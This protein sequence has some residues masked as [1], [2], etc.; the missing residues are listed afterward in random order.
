LNYLTNR[1]L[2][3]RPSEQQDFR[4]FAVVNWMTRLT[5][6]LALLLS[7]RAMAGDWPQFRGP[8]GNGVAQENKAPLHWGP[9]TNVLW[10]VTLPGPGNSSPIVSHGRVFI[11][12]AENEGRKRN[13]Y[14]FDRRTGAQLWVRTV[15]FPSVEPTHQSNP[16]CGSTPVA[17]G[18]RVVVWH[19]SAGVFCYNFKGKELW[20]TDLGE[21]R[22]EWGYGS[23]PILHRG[24]IILN[25]GPGER[26]FLAALD[27]RTG[28]LL[29]K[30]DEPGGAKTLLKGNWGSWCTPIVAKVG[31]KDQVLCSM[32]TQ[33]VACDPKTGARLWFCEGLGEA[34]ADLVYPSPVV[35]GGIGV[36]FTGWV[37]G[38]TMGF[39]LGG[40]GDVTASNR[41][42][43]EKQTQRVGSGVVVGGN[44]FIVNAGPGTA[45]CME[46]Q[47]GK[48]RWSER[49]EG[50]ESWG[51]VVMAAGRLYV[52]SRKGVTTVFRPDPEKLEVLAMNDLGESSNATPA[53]SD[54]QI[55]L[56]TDGHLYCIAE[57]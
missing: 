7:L 6:A 10:Q 46:C 49:L 25:F 48:V 33:V 23:S 2:T 57:D 30:F 8:F 4:M 14:C 45:Q 5:V 37:N 41:L 13:L 24:K 43:L 31:R 44:V 32:L 55:F 1:A 40:S 29:W 36:A 17:D 51:S 52:T 38:P 34:L 54:G 18:A 15:A 19:G 3:Y 22:N 53:I 28:K 11:T 9:G 35:A 27:L 20:K 39:K 16:Y 26:A 56:R 21:V 47:T 42:W 50:G 12:C